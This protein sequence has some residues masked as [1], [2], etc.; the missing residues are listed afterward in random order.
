[1][2]KLNRG[3]KNPDLLTILNSYEGELLYKWGYEVGIND[4]NFQ[5][6]KGNLK[7]TGKWN[8]NAQI[9][10]EYRDK[11]NKFLIRN[12]FLGKLAIYNIFEI[13][14]ISVGI[15]YFKRENDSETVKILNELLL[16]INRSPIRIILLE[17]CV[18]ILFLM[19]INLALK[20]TV[21]EIE[22]QID[23][24]K[25]YIKL[26]I[27]CLLK[28]DYI[29]KDKHD[30][31]NYYLSEKSFNL[32]MNN[33]KSDFGTHLKLDQNQYKFFVDLENYFLNCRFK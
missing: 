2:K 18:E 11:I 29:K 16:K 1:M 3:K 5:F 20:I 24:G 9:E 33:F 17:D 8:P 31:E 7:R 23:V 22:Y 13:G 30:L 14:Y 26:L 15:D 6:A 21:R 12:E 28:F 10:S 27:N 25:Y 19:T 32:I 4:I